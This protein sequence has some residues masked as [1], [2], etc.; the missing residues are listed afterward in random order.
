MIV[1]MP[2]FA[3]WLG[4]MTMK[5]INIMTENTILIFVHVTMVLWL[6]CLP[7]YFAP[8]TAK[9]IEGSI[10]ITLRM[11]ASPIFPM[12]IP[13]SIVVIT[14]WLAVC[15]AILSEAADAI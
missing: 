12:I 3:I 5:K 15:C 11:V 13:E 1:M 10:P 9:M 7:A 2:M 8:T 14:A 4:S 6:P